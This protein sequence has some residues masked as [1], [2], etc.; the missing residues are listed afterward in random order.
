MVHEEK[1]SPG[2]VENAARTVR[3]PTYPL[4]PIRWRT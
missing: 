3:Q 2:R 4:A 1:L